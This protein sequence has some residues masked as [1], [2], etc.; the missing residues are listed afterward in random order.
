[1]QSFEIDSLFAIACESCLNFPV[2]TITHA[3]YRLAPMIVATYSHKVSI[4]I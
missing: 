2:L 1:M 3:S 4:L